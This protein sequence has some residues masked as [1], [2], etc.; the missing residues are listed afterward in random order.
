MKSA[1]K[2]ESFTDG[3]EKIKKNCSLYA[4][5]EAQGV[6]DIYSKYSYANK[7]NKICVLDIEICFES[8]KEENNEK[9]EESKRKKLDRID[10]LLFNREEKIIRFY[11]AKH[12]LN[13]EIRSRSEEP[14]VIDQIRR[15]KKQIDD[16]GSKILDQYNKYVGIV[17]KLFNLGLPIPQSIGPFIVLFVFGFDNQQKK[18]LATELKKLEG[19]KYYASGSTKTLKIG[20]MWDNL[21]NL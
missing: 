8:E 2:L 4:G 12:Y 20:S 6:S 17:N 19:I 21:N 18:K 16:N 13:N 15:Y 3:Y 9:K 11:E 5:P 7:N 10:L 14:D 1:E